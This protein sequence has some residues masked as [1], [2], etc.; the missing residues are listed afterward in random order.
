[1]EEPTILIPYDDKMQI[2][3]QTYLLVGRK[4]K[5]DLGFICFDRR[6]GKW[7]HYVNEKKPIVWFDDPRAYLLTLR[8]F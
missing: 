4:T 1:M 2:T 7:Y 5:R 8:G 3:E 6:P